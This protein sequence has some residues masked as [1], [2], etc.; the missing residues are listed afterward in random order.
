MNNNYSKKNYKKKPNNK[1]SSWEGSHK[2]YNKIVSEEGHYYH[3]KVIL[4]AL[5]KL[6]DLKKTK[7]LLD[8]GC[9]QGILARALP[10]TIEYT[11]IDISP[12][13]IKSAK[14]FSKNTKKERD[15]HKPKQTNCDHLQ[16]FLVGD[17]TQKLP[18]EKKDFAVAVMLLS[19]QNIE[20]GESAIKRAAFHLKDQGQ[21]IIVLNHPSFRI[22]RQSSWHFEETKTMSRLISS[23]LSPLK[24]PIQT[25]P[26]KGQK[27]A[28]TY[29]Y[30]NPLSIYSSWLKKHNLYIEELQ[31]L[32]SD[33][34]ST[35][36]R[37]KAEHK[38]RKEIPLFLVISVKK[39]I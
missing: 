11:G 10:Q 24:I 22:P 2:W 9:G 37:A 21:L 36:G 15:T 34:T 12:S 19:L 28:M 32:I 16:K 5:L 30:H 13:L 33:K 39:T 7:S 38:S 35:G 29:S 31:E 20:D 18:I 6:I 27:S 23:Y 26:S 1:K 8:L 4:P 25:A 17:I 3:Q 14:N